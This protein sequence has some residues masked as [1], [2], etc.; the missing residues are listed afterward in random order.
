[1]A[2]HNQRADSP[3]ASHPTDTLEI[4]RSL[5]QNQ[6]NIDLRLKKIE[7]ASKSF[8]KKQDKLN[9]KVDGIHKMFI[10]WNATSEFGSSQKSARP[11]PHH[12]QH[13]KQPETHTTLT[14]EEMAFLKK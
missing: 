13:P 4:I 3:S 10:Q 2:T 7:D 9:E 11:S 8:A 6:Q 12:H 5:Q 14:L 1:M